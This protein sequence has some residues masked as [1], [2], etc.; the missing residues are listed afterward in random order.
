MPAPEVMTLARTWFR[1][2]EEDLAAA[3]HI[4]GEADVQPRHACWLA[5]QAAEKAL[6]TA[7]V[8]EQTDFPRSHDLEQLQVLIPDSWAVH[9]LD[10]DL[11]TLSR[12]ATDARYPGAAE[13]TRDN[14]LRAVAIARDVVASVRADLR[15]KGVA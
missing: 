4:A 12:W 15:T 10:L 13:A 7:L 9:T 14:A 5:Q 6:K 8:V 1:Y 11:A 3:E 2:A